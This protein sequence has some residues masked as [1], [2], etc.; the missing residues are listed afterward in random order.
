MLAHL[1]IMARSPNVVVCLDSVLGGVASCDGALS[2]G[3]RY[4]CIVVRPVHMNIGLVVA[5]RY[6]MM[7]EKLLRLLGVYS[8]LFS[9]R[10]QDVVTN[11]C[12]LFGLRSATVESFV[13]L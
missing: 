1:C 7:F 13:S 12:Y 2:R 3:C 11:C 6:K 9:V 4:K 5:L 8:L 10:V